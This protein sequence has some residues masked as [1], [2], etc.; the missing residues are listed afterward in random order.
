MTKEALKEQLTLYIKNSDNENDNGKFK[1][2]KTIIKDFSDIEREYL[3]E[4][5]NELYNDGYVYYSKGMREKQSGYINIVKVYKKPLIKLEKTTNPKKSLLNIFFMFILSFGV[6]ISTKYSTDAMVLVGMDT[7]GIS[8]IIA[9]LIS[10]LSIIC[11]SII[12]NTKGTDR[13]LIGIGLIIL[14]VINLF[15]TTTVISND[16]ESERVSIDPN[17]IKY[18]MLN[19]EKKTI[20]N[21]IDS[22]HQQKL[23]QLEEAKRLINIT[24]SINKSAT[25]EWR[26]R[27]SQSKIDKLN[28]ELSEINKKISYLSSNNLD[29]EKKKNSYDIIATILKVDSNLI[30]VLVS[31]MLSFVYDVFCP[32]LIGLIL[33]K[34]NL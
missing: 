6:I 34:K 14:V 18:Q 23:V 8:L 11:H 7:K 19:E 26:A 30:V 9:F 4:I 15:C 32:F 29:V 24:N 10:S 25:Y 27:Q 3:L 28:I 17:T 16:Y 12:R 33:S 21:S 2:F 31:I 20:L 1:T 5:L 13:V 22:T